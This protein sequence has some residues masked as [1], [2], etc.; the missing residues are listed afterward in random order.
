MEKWTVK[1]PAPFVA[2]MEAQLADEM[3]AFMASYARGRFYGLRVNTLKIDVARY[4]ARAPFA[5][6]PVAWAEQGFYYEESDRPGRH[7][8]YHAG[9]YYIQEPSAMA[10]VEYLDVQPGEKVL[11][12]CAAPGGKSTQIAAKLQGQGLLVS[13]DQS[14]ERT[15][16]L[17]KNLELFGVSNAVVMNESPH[18]MSRKWPN[19]FDKILVDAP[20]SGE[21]MFR[22]D[23]EM[24]REWSESSVAKCVLMQTD[25]LQHAAA[26][27][28]PGGTLVYSTCTFAPQENEWIVARFLRAQP[29]FEVLPV[30]LAPGFVYGRA[31]WLAPEEAV[32]EALCAAVARTVRLWPQRLEGEGHFLAVLRKRGAAPGT[33]T[34]RETAAS[35]GTA[36]RFATYPEMHDF[37]AST[38]QDDAQSALSGRA[39]AYGDHVYRLHPLTPPLDGLKV[40]RPGTYLGMLKKRR[41][42]PAH[43]LA[44]QLRPEHVRYALS[45]AADD[46]RVLRYLRGET[47]TLDE[48]RW[49]GTGK[50]YVL[51]CVD[52]YALGW[53]KWQD[54]ILKNEYPQAWRRMT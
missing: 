48:P 4:L 20:C 31:D 40:V 30:A 12:L 22:K 46:E 47:L 1:L 38:L 33:V 45:F 25:I 10:P 7:V 49:A 18:R 11:D 32:D 24:W 51:V 19:F 43:A 16:A 14:A 3:A 26:M 13:N 42:E 9:L 50:V 34:E 5:L 35:G 44:L 23:E 36:I 54:G 41:F 28:A 29:D 8:D 27:L 37:F 52:G 39:I 6:R 15:K 17:V 53:G 21:G 2:R